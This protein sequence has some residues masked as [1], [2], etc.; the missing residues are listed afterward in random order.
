[1]KIDNLTVLN[2]LVSACFVGTWIALP[3]AG[4]FLFHRRKDA[5]FRRKWHPRG[6]ILVG[7]LFIFFSTT[8]MGL[9]SRSLGTLGAALL[10]VVPAV[11]LIS[12]MNIRFTKICHKCGYTFYV[13]DWFVPVKFCC[14]CG[15][16]LE[17]KPS[18]DDDLPG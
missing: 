15:A 1:M 7:V 17:P 13:Q 16:E 10:L 5:A 8:I 6:V 4:Y 9:S 11:C 12:Y 3:V 18:L 14:R 2:G